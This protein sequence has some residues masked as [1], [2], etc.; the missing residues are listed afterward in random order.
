MCAE[1]I[2][3]GKMRKR[4][5]ALTAALVL[6]TVSIGAVVGEDDEV[7][8][9]EVDTTKLYESMAAG[10]VIELSAETLKQA[11]QVR[12]VNITAVLLLIARK[13][14]ESPYRRTSSCSLSFTLRGAGIARL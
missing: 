6:L 5:A 1:Y 3:T 10:T 12:A 8:A 14:T 7:D 13:F 9:A 11:M 2:R 4:L